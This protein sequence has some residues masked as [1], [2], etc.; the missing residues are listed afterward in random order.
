M[1]AAM[2]LFLH[3]AALISVSQAAAAIGIMPHPAA[4]ISGPV[5]VHDGVAGHV[6]IHGG[7]TAAGHT[8]EAAGADSTDID[9]DDLVR[10]DDAGTAPSMASLCCTAAVMPVPPAHAVF[11]GIVSVITAAPHD[12]L[13]GVE[14]GGLHRP[15]RTPDI[16]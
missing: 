14:P 3:Q 4:T 16:A 1:L 11:L 15:P 10:D 7:N 6:H 8:H 2:A 9:H 5:H 12:P 13:R